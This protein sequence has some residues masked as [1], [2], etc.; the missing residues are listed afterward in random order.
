QDPA[1]LAAVSANL[2]GAMPGLE[3]SEIPAEERL[4]E[5]GW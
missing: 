2:Q 1:K 4:Q 5:R 3:M